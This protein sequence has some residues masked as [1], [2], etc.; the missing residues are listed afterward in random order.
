M[1]FDER[2]GKSAIPASLRLPTAPDL[3]ARRANVVAAG[4][5]PLGDAR[6]PLGRRFA[7]APPRRRLRRCPRADEASLGRRSVATRAQLG[8]SWRG[9]VAEGY[10]V[11]V[12]QGV[13]RDH[14]LEVRAPLDLRGRRGG[15]PCGRSCRPTRAS[16]RT[17]CIGLWRCF[18][19]LA[20]SRLA[21]GR[22]DGAISLSPCDN[23]FGTCLET[24]RW[25]SSG[26]ASG[27]PSKST[28]GTAGGLSAVSP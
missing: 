7:L 14:G 1:R 12:A 20:R 21:R 6:A 22:L 25:R 23:R 3:C 5:V 17:R 11:A 18:T 13:A 2:R 8:H 15:G 24:S 16:R 9:L 19:P 4:R 27:A 26:S 28:Q 10:G